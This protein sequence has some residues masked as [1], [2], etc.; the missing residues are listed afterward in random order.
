MAMKQPT[1]TPTDTPVATKPSPEFDQA[2]PAPDTP[3]GV[4]AKANMYGAFSIETFCNAGPLSLTHDDTLGFL[5]YV[6]QF[7]ARNFWYQDDG[8]KVWAYYED[9][10][11]WQD[12]YGMDAVRVAYHCG[13]G[14]MDANGVFY[15]PMGAAWAGNDCTAT[16]NSMRLGDEYAR[17][18]YWSTCESLRVFGGHSPSRTWS[19]ANQGLRM[20]FGFE[21]VSWDD[22]RYGSGF[23]NHWKKG[24]SFSSA[25]LNSSWDIAHDQAPSVVAM[26][27]TQQE[28]QERVYNERFFYA[29]RASSNWWWWRWYNTAGSAVRT[30]LHTVPDNP[31]LG[32][33][34]PAQARSLKAAADRFAMDVSGAQQRKGFVAMSDGERQV[35]IDDDGVL[36]AVLS[37]PNIGN[38]SPLGRRDAIGVA[39]DAVRTYGLDADA[40]LVLDRVVELRE[41]GASEQGDG[42]AEGPFTT[43][44]LVQYRQLINGM[45]VITPHA[46]TVQVTI[47]NDGTVTNVRAS[48]REIDSLSDRPRSL[49]PEPPP[50]GADRV[51]E[52]VRD[53]DTALANAFG[54]R[55]RHLLLKG[56]APVGFSTVPGTSEVG[57]EMRN[58]EAVIIAQRAVEVE[59]TGG[60][61]KRYWIKAPLYG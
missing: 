39:D 48:T 57:Y 56:P 32:V 15:V 37:S 7:D 11:N 50:F 3:G 21:T 20:I 40:D 24:E 1:R 8:V 58:S 19:P 13:H 22:A 42:A 47:D 29:D 44:T 26:G 14:G 9:Y 23:W 28:A 2:N 16:S 25:W 33:L 38:R 6:E 12:T 18:V 31:R 49:A 30:P 4:R 60:F 46:G 61:R 52:E 34:A 17:Y 51:S 41:A 59:F 55:L 43:G 45:P 27:S 10:D 35:S 54:D 53:P 36:T 5:Q